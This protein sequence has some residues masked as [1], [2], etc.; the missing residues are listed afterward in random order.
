MSGLDDTWVQMEQQAANAAAAGTLSMRIAP[1]S[2]LDLHVT[3][4]APA[5]R[6]GL[7]LKVQAG[8]IPK[9]VELPETSGL[10]HVVGPPS[11]DGRQT[12]VLRL[13]D[14]SANDLFDALATDLVGHVVGA[15]SEAEA[16]QRWMGR[17]AQWRRIFALGRT[18][19]S[20]NRQRGL[21]AELF[22]LR[23]HLIEAVGLESAIAGWEGPL[24]GRDLQ[25]PN[26]SFEVKSS[27]ATEPQAVRI[28]SERQLDTVG[29]PRLYLVHLSLA[30]EL[31]KGETLPALVESL[32]AHAAGTASA[33]T[34]EDRL[35][36]AGYLPM[37]ESRYRSTGYAIRR[38]GFYEVRDGFPRIL[39]GDL[40]PG[41]G[42]VRYDLVLDICEPYLV[43]PDIALSGLL[44]AAT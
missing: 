2:A 19:L 38:E 35:F 13:K 7:T 33:L 1:D 40:A 39:E 21:Y 3:L 20:P 12:I 16:V 4:T 29:C 5:N 18:G 22:V 30:V 11:D 6:R 41:I 15:G 27:A 44:E 43:P 37:H 42:N 24:G 36:A 26:A 8:A 32:R 31:G 34:L 25:Y 9:A 17:V 28:N 14:A 10:E 23:N